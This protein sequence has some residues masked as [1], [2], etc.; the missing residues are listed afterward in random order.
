MKS[1]RLLLL[2]FL[3]AGSLTCVVAQSAPQED[4]GPDGP[5]VW[6][7]YRVELRKKFLA[8]KFEELE[9]LADH[10]RLTEDRFPGGDWKLRFFYESFDP[11]L[12]NN[13]EKKWTEA[14][15]KMEEWLLA[16][17][18]S[19]T[20]RLVAARLCQR[21]AGRLKG[22]ERKAM[23]DR[24]THFLE[25]CKTRGPDWYGVR[26]QQSARSVDAW[27]VEQRFEACLEALHHY[28]TYTDPFVAAA[29]YDTWY[30]DESPEPMW[31]LI[32]TVE[33]DEH[34]RREGAGARIFS[35]VMLNRNDGPRVRFDRTKISKSIW[36]VL[37]DSFRHLLHEWPNAW[38]YQHQFACTAAAV[39][40]RETAAE[41]FRDLPEKGNNAKEIWEVPGMR[42][43]MERW[44]LHPED[45]RWLRPKPTWDVDSGEFIWNHCFSPDGKYLATGDCNGRAFLLDM[46]ALQSRT[47]VINGQSAESLFRDM[48]PELPQ[49]GARRGTRLNSG[50]AFSPDGQH[51]A[52]SDSSESDDKG[53]VRIWNLASGAKEPE[54]IITDEKAI[55]WLGFDSSGT[56]LF[57][58]A[59]SGNAKGARVLRVGLKDSPPEVIYNRWYMHALA[60]HHASHQVG[61]AESIQAFVWNEDELAPK[62][63][64][65]TLPKGLDGK[66]VVL[67]FAPDGQ[68]LLACGGGGDRHGWVHRFDL[69]GTTHPALAVNEIPAG[70]HVM[71]VDA[72]HNC[73]LGG[74]WDGGVYVWDLA[75][76][77]LIA[78]FPAVMDTHVS[79]LSVSPNGKWLAIADASRARLLFYNLEGILAGRG[80]GEM[81]R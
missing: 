46:T 5:K 11:R 21:R 48:D 1:L 81:R 49:R 51:F 54:R 16:A 79:A 14:L 52:A 74:G 57:T 34:A 80:K 23:A 68:S 50:L 27:S 3:A 15:K 26:L 33:N 60:V 77:K 30:D 10:L 43:V 66:I 24:A 20:V 7:E 22:D 28:P 53:Q 40:D 25:Q 70:I 72:T 69:N 58:L 39:G 2:F 8:G 76:G 6:Q 31:Q 64:A 62:P 42:T 9:K 61:L 38:W 44:A 73:V 63:P 17:P 13:D 55:N 41:A 67:A 37:R 47:G 75:S 71:D 32:R 4:E 19:D 35:W 59:G 78:A 36:P 56:H 18:D 45:P 65:M 12:D 29:L